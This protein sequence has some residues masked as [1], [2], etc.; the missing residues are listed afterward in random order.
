MRQVIA[1][2]GWNEVFDIIEESICT[3][4]EQEDSTAKRHIVDA[5]KKASKDF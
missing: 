5:V 2:N 1:K 4:N 3:L